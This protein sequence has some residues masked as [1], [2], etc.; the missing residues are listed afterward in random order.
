MP[1][2]QDPLLTRATQAPSPRAAEG[3]GQTAGSANAAS[4]EEGSHLNP[5][6]RAAAQQRQEA[7]RRRLEA[8]RIAALQQIESSAP[9]GCDGAQA[10]MTA[11]RAEK[12]H[13]QLPRDV[14]ETVDANCNRGTVLDPSV[15]SLREACSSCG[16]A[17]QE[18]EGIVRFACAHVGHAVCI[19]Q[20]MAADLQAADGHGLRWIPRCFQCNHS[21]GEG[22]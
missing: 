5:V 17:Y 9:T 4:A 6:L 8:S 2:H 1:R 20:W 11:E 16:S 3:T 18:R 10:D 22:P 12:V 15:P 19:Y 13:A 7:A 14:R 21:S